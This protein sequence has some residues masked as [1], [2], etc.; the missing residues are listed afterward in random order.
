MDRQSR[1]QDRDDCD[2]RHVLTHAADEGQGVARGL[3]LRTRRERHTE[4]DAD[5]CHTEHGH[6][7][8]GAKM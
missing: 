6:V 8:T 7:T 1:Q 2:G 3:H 5:R 4:M